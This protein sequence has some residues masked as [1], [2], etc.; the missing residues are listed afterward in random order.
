MDQR[1]TNN[2]PIDARPLIARRGLRVLVVSAAIIFPLTFCLLLKPASAHAAW[3]QFSRLLQLKMDPAGTAGQAPD[4]SDARLKPLPPQQQAEIV[5]MVTKGKK[6]AADAARLFNVHP[7][8]IS[9]LLAQA[10][11]VPLARR[12]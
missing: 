2:N 1:F 10:R 6:T 4:I 5:R 11:T 8:T 12:S 9:R 7:A 3:V